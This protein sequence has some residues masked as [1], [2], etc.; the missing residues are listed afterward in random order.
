MIT[1]Q[2]QTLIIAE[3]GDNHNGDIR[4]AY[5]LIDAAVDARADYVKFQTFKTESV[6]SKSAAAALYQREN[7]GVDISQYELLKRLEL[8]FEQ[9]GNLKKYAENK[10][11]GF[12]SSP[13]DLESIAYLASI[14][15]DLFKIPSGEISNLPYLEKIASYRKPVIM[16]TGMSTLPEI[17]EALAVLRNGGCNDISLMHCNTGY[18]TPY[19]DV[20]LKAMQTLKKLFGL[21][22]GYSD[23]TLGLEIPLAAVALGAEIIEKHFTLNRHLKGPD[24]KASLEPGELKAMIAAIRKVE[25]ALGD[26]IK[27]VSPSEKP[28]QAAAR[29]SIT[30]AKNIRKGEIFDTGNLTVKRPGNG[31]SPMKWYAV[32]GEKAPRDFAADELIEL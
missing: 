4:L 3:A 10:K 5:E 17:K 29:K 32:L 24:H 15:L 1:G 6:V 11:I 22:V 14:D 9:F 23:H 8:P 18:P 27:T 30:A 16:S 20:N 13:F 21:R 28:N 26:G 31:I 2:H 19:Q 25:M 12:I 7:L